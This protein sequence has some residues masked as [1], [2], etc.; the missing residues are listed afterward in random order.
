MRHSRTGGSWVDTG[1]VAFAAGGQRL[2]QVSGKQIVVWNPETGK[3]LTAWDAAGVSILR[4]AVAPGGR[5]AATVDPRESVRVWNLDDQQEV[6]S[7]PGHYSALAIHPSGDRFAAV[8][9]DKQAV[10]ASLSDCSE[11]A[12]WPVDVKFSPSV[13][14]AADGKHLVLGSSAGAIHVYGEDG[15]ESSVWRGQAKTSFVYA[16]ATGSAHVLSTALGADSRALL[17]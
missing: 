15:T 12:R 8:G 4:L 3:E 9:Y 10:I 16:A 6:C 11:I 13:T 7:L 5:V 17:W 14:W 1:P 2:L